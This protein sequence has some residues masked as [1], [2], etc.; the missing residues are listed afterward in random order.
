[1]LKQGPLVRLMACDDD[2]YEPPKLANADY[3][4]VRVKNYEFFDNDHFPPE[5]KDIMSMNG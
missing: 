4:L 2:S 1:M 3:T 5:T